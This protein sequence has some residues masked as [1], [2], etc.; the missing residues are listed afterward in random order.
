MF[1][2]EY[3]AKSFNFSFSLEGV[4]L[5]VFEKL[6]YCSWLSRIVLCKKSG[7]FF[8][9]LLLPVTLWSDTKADFDWPTQV[10]CVVSGLCCARSTTRII[11][12]NSD[13]RDHGHKPLIYVK[14]GRG[15]G[16]SSFSTILFCTRRTRQDPAHSQTSGQLS[17]FLLP[18]HS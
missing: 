6:G 2:F 11:Q 5:E 9:H 10:T 18:K 15:A 1:H 17:G 16:G 3:Y 8:L 4:P 7:R 13:D 14:D 12:P